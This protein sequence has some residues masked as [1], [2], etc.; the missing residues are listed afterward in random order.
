MKVIC[1]QCNKEF[2]KLPNQILKSKNDFCSRS[3]SATF[4][5]KLKP[6]RNPISRTC[7]CGK[8]FIPKFKSSRRLCNQC[9][10]NKLTSFKIKLL[11]ISEY[12]KKAS[13]KDKHPSWKNSHIRIFNRQWNYELTKKPCF[14]CGYDKHVELCHIKPVSSFPETATLG[15]INALSNNIQLCRNCHWEYDHG[16]FIL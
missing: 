10:I 12:H 5:N 6:K 16:L 1:K 7:S 9:Q 14:K 2:D 11:T 13:I 3:C 8:K 15:E 4:N